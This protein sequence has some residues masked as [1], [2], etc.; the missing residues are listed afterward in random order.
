MAIT[1]FL[2]IPKTFSWLEAFA[3]CYILIY[4]HIFG[5]LIPIKSNI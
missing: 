5:A 3:F 4:L 2:M 1:I